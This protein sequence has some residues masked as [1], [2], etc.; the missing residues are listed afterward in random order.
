[1]KDKLIYLASAV[2]LL[3]VAAFGVATV[4]LTATN[5]FK[6]I[7][8][9]EAFISAFAGAFFTFILVKF[10]ELGTRLRNVERDNLQGLVAINHALMAHMNQLSN[11]DFVAKD[12]I[13]TY[14]K[15]TTT[16]EPI[17]I[18]FNFFKPIPF[19]PNTLKVL[20]NTKFL[21]E[22][23]GY[24]ADIEKLNDS[25]LSLQKFID[26]LTDGLISGN[27]SPADYLRNAPLLSVKTKEL[28]KFIKHSL[29]EAERLST[30]NRLL[31]MHRSILWRS[32]VNIKTFDEYPKKVTEGF[33]AEMK[34]IK[35]EIA[36]TFAQSRKE[37]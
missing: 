34:V 12:I 20:R 31:I 23:Y 29:S 25:Q 30:L 21:N 32:A 26:V 11:A 19:D 4:I 24:Y 6:T 13:A 33:D 1:L 9:N 8:N 37:I 10:A 22:V 16:T 7:A 5:G 2:G 17:A 18:N 14:D 27:L 36:D 35:Q 15:A 28:R 3:A